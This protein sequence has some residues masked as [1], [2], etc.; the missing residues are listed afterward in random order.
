MQKVRTLLHAL[1]C[2]NNPV[3]WFKIYMFIFKMFVFLVSLYLW[4]IV[5][6]IANKSSENDVLIFFSR[7]HC[8]FYWSCSMTSQSSSVITIMDSVM[9]SH[10][11]VFRCVT[12]Y[13]VLSLVTWGFLIH[14]HQTSRLTCWQ[15]F[16]SH[17]A[18]LSTL[19]A[20]YSLLSSRR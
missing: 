7:E 6:M 5:F 13:W 12:W 10:L 1:K 14:L 20:R 3:S 17:P 19:Q 16:H 4:R 15:T 2:S 8:E 18:F 11:I 9:S